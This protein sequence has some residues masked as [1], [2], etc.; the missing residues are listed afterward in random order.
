MSK[1]QRVEAILVVLLSLK[2][3]VI[4]L[5]FGKQIRLRFKFFV[6]DIIFFFLL[7]YNSSQLICK[8]FFSLFSFGLQGIHI[9]LTNYPDLNFLF[10]ALRTKLKVEKT[11][12]S[13]LFL[14]L[15]LMM[16]DILRFGMERLNLKLYIGPR[17]LFSLVCC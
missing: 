2:L 15:T 5:N 1:Q 12:T 6:F 9:W 8:I 16:L 3:L 4:D 13:S 7:N 10:R 14:L 11:E 17:S